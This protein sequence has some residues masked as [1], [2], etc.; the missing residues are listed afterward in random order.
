MGLFCRCLCCKT[1]TPVD[2]PPT[3]ENFYEVKDD[4]SG[5][6]DDGRSVYSNARSQLPESRLSLSGRFSPS[7]FQVQQQHQQQQPHIENPRAS[8]EKQTIWDWLQGFS[9]FVSHGAFLETDAVGE[10]E[11]IKQ[12]QEVTAELLQVGGEDKDEQQSESEGGRGCLPIFHPPLV[13]GPHPHPHHGPGTPEFDHQDSYRSSASKSPNAPKLQHQKTLYR[14][15]DAS[16]GREPRYCWCPA[17][18]QSFRVRSKEYVKTRR[19]EPCAGQIYELA[20]VDLFSFEK[21]VFHIAKHIDLPSH[22]VNREWEEKI[23][24]PLLIINITG[25]IYPA[26]LFG[27]K[28]GHGHSL[29]YYFSLP[30]DFK[31]DEF[32]NKGAADLLRKFFNGEKNHQFRERLKIIPRIVN[33]DEWAK[34][35]PLSTPELVLLKKY[36][37]KPVMTGPTHKFFRG[38]GYFE[39]DVDIHVYPFVA[40]KAFQGYVGRL[41]EVVFENAFI[42]QGNCEE[43]LPELVLGCSRVFRVDFSKL[44][45]VP[46]LKA[47][48]N[49]IPEETTLDMDNIALEENSD[50]DE[51]DDKKQEEHGAD[52]DVKEGEQQVQ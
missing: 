39:I 50:D 13:R 12:V 21:K 17:D 52:L 30:Q 19:K 38:H 29:V 24:P 14:L 32:E 9:P 3:E 41:G 15:G 37:D 28:D 35:G 16:S 18:P 36:N 7:H 51:E 47:N 4:L 22:L 34:R 2:G 48:D 27:E 46:V 20:G 33:V 45:P 10:P 6:S 43:E 1:G 44:Y 5:A 31:L 40:R 42:L 11:T 49:V 25:P 8:I 23:I 26:V